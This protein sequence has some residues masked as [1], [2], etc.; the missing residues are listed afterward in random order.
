MPIWFDEEPSETSKARY[1]DAVVRYIIAN[2][3]R[4][5]IP[6][7]SIQFCREL[8]PYVGQLEEDWM[9][10]TVSTFSP[11]HY[12]A[13]K[14]FEDTVR[15]LIRSQKKLDQML[16]QAD[17]QK[18]EESEQEQ[19]IQTQ[20]AV[21]NDISVQVRSTSG[22]FMPPIAPI[23]NMDYPESSEDG[24]PTPHLPTR[25]A[26]KR[27]RPRDDIVA[28]EPDAKRMKLIQLD[29]LY[30]DFCSK[31]RAAKLAEKMWRE[32]RNDVECIR[33]PRFDTD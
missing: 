3:R 10:V 32:A 25:I 12:R 31:M 8:I 20:Q 11:G 9:K 29:E 5:D 6:K 30:E 16:A 4:D 1:R 18:S 27:P 14:V 33:S 22:Q 7:P 21:P 19:I 26:K 17:A 24:P 2:D 13:H 28:E 15:N 23:R